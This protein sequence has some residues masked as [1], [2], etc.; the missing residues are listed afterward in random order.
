MPGV[1]S[2]IALALLLG[3][4]FF[5]TVTVHELGHAIP[6]LLMT[7]GEVTIFIGSFGNPYQS[8]NVKI[9]RINF[10]CKYNP[11]LWYKGC[12]LC[13]DN[14]LSINQQIWYVAAGPIASILE[15][16]LTWF[17]ISNLQQEDF[18]R[19][20]FGSIFVISL[21]AT[22]YVL[23]PNPVPRYTA[24]GYPIYSDTYQIFRLLR[25]KQRR[26]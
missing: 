22:G 15:T 3:L 18:L 11:L 4:A 24:S 9:G 26:Y 8:F 14:Y 21:G 2:I 5:V 12:C 1:L 10:Y 7:R 17:L 20:V 25:L 6:A 13:S 23:V 19:I 16:I